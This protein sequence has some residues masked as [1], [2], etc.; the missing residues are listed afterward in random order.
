MIYKGMTKHKTSLIT[1]ITASGDLHLGSYLGTMSQWKQFAENHNCCFFIADLHAITTPQPPE[2][3]RQKSLDMLAMF[4]SCQID[5][6][7]HTIFIQSQVPQHTEL[8][9]VL[10]CIASTGE[11]NRMTQF[12]DKAS[13]R[14]TS[15][16]GL[17]GYPCLMAADILLYDAN[18]VPVG[19][20]QKQ[21]LELTRNIAQRFNRTHGEI[22]TIPE[23]IIPKI[24][25]R[26][27]SLQDPENKMSKSDKNTNN[28]IY[29]LDQPEIIEKKIK[30]AVT[31]SLATI[32]YVKNRPAISNLVQIYA[33]CN[34]ISIEDTVKEFSGS[35]YGQFKKALADSIISM[36]E[37]LQKKY[38]EI[39][40]DKTLLNKT[41]QQG[42]EKA[43]EKASA[44]L[45]EVYSALGL[46]HYDY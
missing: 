45:K 16:L 12:K 31:D 35:G 42:A 22:F 18:Y 33:A 44:K 5:I 21:H 39:R 37:P 43:R 17:Y 6:N 11:L 41:M 13:K 24:A 26:V 28:S 3:L 19:D 7:Q 23:A 46:A 40:K 32:D 1:G 30:K 34:S 36:L 29:L 10:S 2:I 9:W 4:L 15:S 20:D 14:E 27:M 38:F 25:A 8:S